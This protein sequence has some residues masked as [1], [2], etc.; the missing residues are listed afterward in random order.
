MLKIPLLILVPSEYS[1][2]VDPDGKV[3][4]GPESNPNTP[5]AQGW[6]KKSHYGNPVQQIPYRYNKHTQKL[7]PDGSVVNK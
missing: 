1:I 7:N 6:W 2:E 3:K 4:P 5:T